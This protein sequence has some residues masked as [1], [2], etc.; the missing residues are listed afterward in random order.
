MP[1]RIIQYPVSQLYMSIFQRE[2]T[3]HIKRKIFNGKREIDEG[4]EKREKGKNENNNRKSSTILKRPLLNFLRL[5][6]LSH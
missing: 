4:M 3:S 1:F 2:G 5:E 6:S